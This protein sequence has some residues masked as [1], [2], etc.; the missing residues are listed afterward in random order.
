MD[1]FFYG[2]LERKVCSRSYKNLDKLKKAISKNWSKIN[3]VDLVTACKAFR[4]QIEAVI[5]AD[6]GHIEKKCI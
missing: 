1:Y 4:G 6:G 2:K 5:K 3:H